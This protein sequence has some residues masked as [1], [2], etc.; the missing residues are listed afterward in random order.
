VHVAEVVECVAVRTVAFAVKQIRAV[1]V[2]VQFAVVICA[3][4]TFTPGHR[5]SGR[6]NLLV[7]ILHRQLPWPSVKSSQHL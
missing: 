4:V 6:Y 2:D 7:L 1:Q 3:A 5:S